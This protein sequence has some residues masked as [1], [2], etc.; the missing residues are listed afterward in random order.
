MNHQHVRWA[1]PAVSDP[2]GG[3]TESGLASSS[4]QEFDRPAAQ[5]VRAIS[6][7]QFELDL[8]LLDRSAVQN[9]DRTPDGGL[10]QVGGPKGKPIR[11][12]EN[13]AM[14][15]LRLSFHA[16]APIQT[17]SLYVPPMRPRSLVLSV[18]PITKEDW[19]DHPHQ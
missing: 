9:Q 16:D 13:R 14:T 15:G 12:L 11:P 2:N 3:G 8:C 17:E 6:F 1:G 19:D 10:D 5:C 18:I 4:M 7:L